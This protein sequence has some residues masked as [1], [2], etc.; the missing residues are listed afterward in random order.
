MDSKEFKKIRKKLNRT[1]KE[2]APLLGVSK[3]AIRSYEQGWR[4]IPPHV[5]RQ[6]LYLLSRMDGNSKINRPCWVIKNCHPSIKVHCPAWEFNSG[7]QCW[8][9]NGNISRGEVCKDWKMKMK[10]YRSCEVLQF[11][12]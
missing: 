2:I 10:R 12:L 7:K 11:F 6:M 5:E 9:V 4:N 3:K 8:F 1:Q